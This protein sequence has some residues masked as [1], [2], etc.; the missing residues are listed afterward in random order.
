MFGVDLDLEAIVPIGEDLG[1]LPVMPHRLPAVDLLVDRSRE[2]ERLRRRVVDLRS[3]LRLGLLEADGI[4]AWRRA[5][6]A[7]LEDT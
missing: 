3:A 1:P 2:L 5:H 4:A 7:L 6:G